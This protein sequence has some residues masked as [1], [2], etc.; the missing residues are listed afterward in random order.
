DTLGPS[1]RATRCPA[2][3]ILG[4]DD[5]LPQPDARA[6]ASYL[7]AN[8]PE[9]VCRILPDASHW[10][11]FEQAAEVNRLLIEFFAAHGRRAAKGALV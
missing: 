4:A 5:P 6:R 11:A 8:A 9:L 1:L 7:E 10:V 3:A 2:L